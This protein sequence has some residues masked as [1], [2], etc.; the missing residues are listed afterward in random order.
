MVVNSWWGYSLVKQPLTSQFHIV[1]SRFDYYSFDVPN[2]PEDE[3]GINRAV[4]LIN[5]II[6]AEVKDHNIPSNRIIVG[7][8][9]QGS[10]VSI[11]TALTTTRPLA[12]VFILS[13]Y[14]P[15]RNKAKEARFPSL[16]VALPH[17]IFP[18]SSP[19]HLHNH[20][21]YSGL[22]VESTAK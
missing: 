3:A 19:P 12:G 11:L 7:G 20:Y 17:L 18:C 16:S 2:R 1:A 14:I 21:V 4:G 6:S 22:M 10:A 8:I 13:G 5:D 15:L 9:S